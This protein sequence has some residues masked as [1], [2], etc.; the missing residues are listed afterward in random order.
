M[1]AVDV[2]C[3]NWCITVRYVTPLRILG[4]WLVRLAESAAR[5]RRY[6]S[7]H[8]GTGLRRRH[9]CKTLRC[10]VID[11]SRPDSVNNDD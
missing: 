5:N 7:Q 8:D 11:G 3:R 10:N 6:L 2:L 1:L 4:R 9:L